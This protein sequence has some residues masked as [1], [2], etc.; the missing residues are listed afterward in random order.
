MQGI[1]VQMKWM[2]NKPLKIMIFVKEE[3]LIC[4]DQYTLDQNI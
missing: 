1:K 4:F 2:Q 3:N